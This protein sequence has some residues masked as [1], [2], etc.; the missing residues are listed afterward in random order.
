MALIKGDRISN[1]RINGNNRGSL[2]FLLF[3]TIT[4]YWII[5]LNK[6]MPRTIGHAKRFAS[7]IIKVP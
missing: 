5:I 3:R 2:N 7:S 1:I 4:V 6:K